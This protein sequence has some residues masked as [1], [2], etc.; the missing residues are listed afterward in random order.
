MGKVVVGVDT[1]EEATAEVEDVDT[2]LEREVSFILIR[3]DPKKAGEE[4]GAEE[5][6]SGE[7]G[8]TVGEGVT[9]GEE[10][11]AEEEE[12]AEDA[13]TMI[14]NQCYSLFIDSLVYICLI[15]EW[16]FAQHNLRKVSSLPST[17]S[18]MPR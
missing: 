3:C 8:V 2:A 4:A 16:A 5:I 10:V 15:A 1:K 9:A 11:T 17:P 7:D 13:E 18:S 14:H 12:A 6:T